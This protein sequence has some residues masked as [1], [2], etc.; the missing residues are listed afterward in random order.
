MSTEINLNEVVFVWTGA[1]GKTR[2]FK[3]TPSV[4]VRAFKTRTGKTFYVLLLEEVE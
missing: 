4:G 1:D 3:A 2:R